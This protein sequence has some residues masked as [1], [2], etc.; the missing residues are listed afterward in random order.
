MTTLEAMKGSERLIN[1]VKRESQKPSLA[2]HTEIII[3]CKPKAEKA[4]YQ[5]QELIARVAKLQ[6]WLNSQPQRVCSAKVR[7]LVQTPPSAQSRCL[8]SSWVYFPKALPKIFLHSNLS[9]RVGFPGN[10]TP[11]RAE[12]RIS[13]EH[14]GPCQW[15]SA[16]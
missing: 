15:D 3:S 6:R 16:W 2:A 10:L 4:A 5:V 7:V 9:F 12:G 8:H 11:D 13:K 1:K 14:S